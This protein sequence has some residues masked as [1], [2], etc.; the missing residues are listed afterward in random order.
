MSYL[1][2]FALK[3][4]ESRNTPSSE[5]LLPVNYPSKTE[6]LGDIRAIIC[7]VYGTLINYWRPDFSEVE[8]KERSVL[9]AFRNTATFFGMNE[10]IS[11]VNPPEPPEKTLNDFYNGLITLR[12]DQSKSKGIL[13]PEIKIEQIWELIITILKR[14]GYEPPLKDDENIRDFSRRIAWYYNFCALGRELYPGVFTAL[15]AIKKKNVKIGLLSNAQFYTRIDLTLLLRDQS[16]HQIDDMDELF[17][18]DLTYLSYEYLVAKPEQLLFRKLFD[19]L[20][21]MQILPSQTVYIGN[22]LVNDILPA[23]QIGMKTALFT[24]DT[25]SAFISSGEGKILPD[26]TF[27]H[28]DELESRIEFHKEGAADV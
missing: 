23:Q 26:I 21:E 10:Y 20:Y 28:W 12:H 2:E 9:A 19:A 18:I 27:S 1:A 24:G 15:D 4:H 13:Y 7:D 8:S 14:H 17:D 25:N 16:N 3:I 11:K 5:E 6:K 22:D